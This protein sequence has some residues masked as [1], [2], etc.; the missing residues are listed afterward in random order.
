[1]FMLLLSL[2]DQTHCECWEKSSG[3]WTM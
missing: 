3:L 2:E 1:M